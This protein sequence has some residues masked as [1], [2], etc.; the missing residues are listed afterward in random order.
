MRLSKAALHFNRQRAAATPISE[1]S[2]GTSN[3]LHLRSHR[4]SS[5]SSSSCLIDELLLRKLSE[6]VVVV[7]N[8]PYGRPGFLV[9][10]L[11]GN[12]ASFLC[13]KA[14]MRRIQKKVSGHQ[15][16]LDICPPIRASLSFRMIFIH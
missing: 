3:Q 4:S 2:G 14:P 6:T 10:H 16:Y 9:V 12:R 5:S 1:L 11:I 15:L 8:A 13:T 7:G